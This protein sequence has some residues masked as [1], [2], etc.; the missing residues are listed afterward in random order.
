MQPRASLCE[1]QDKGLGS[2]VRVL[3]GNLPILSM[4]RIIMGAVDSQAVT[5]FSVRRILTNARLPCRL[6]EWKCLMLNGA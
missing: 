5:T 4:P 3:T 6:L 2:R 1:T